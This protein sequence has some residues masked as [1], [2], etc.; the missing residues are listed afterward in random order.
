MARTSTGSEKWWGE[1]L[2]VGNE[3]TDP[4]RAKRQRGR[5]FEFPVCILVRFGVF[6]I[7]FFLS[8]LKDLQNQEKEVTAMRI[9]NDNKTMSESKQKFKCS[10]NSEVS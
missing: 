7:V 6:Y 2:L 1:G 9:Q 4:K 8:T 10:L 5:V 3:V